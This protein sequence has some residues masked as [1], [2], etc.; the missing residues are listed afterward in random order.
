MMSDKPKDIINNKEI[1]E[2]GNYT[3]QTL[4][5][6]LHIIPFQPH[7]SKKHIASGDC[8]CC[9]FCQDKVEEG[10]LHMYQHHAIQ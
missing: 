4:S 7:F 8:W 9:P 10:N 6:D 5:G 2:Y 3:F 1:C